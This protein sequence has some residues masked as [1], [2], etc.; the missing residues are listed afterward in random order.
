[1]SQEVSTSGAQ[2]L[3][4]VLQPD[5]SDLQEVVVVGYGTMQKKDL[6]GAVS[7]VQ[8][9]EIAARKTTQVSTALQGA[10]PGLMVTRSGNAPGASATIRVRGITTLTDAGSNPLIILD[11]VPI[12]D[13]NSINPNDIDN[14]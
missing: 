14:I 9:Q 6:T 13:I 3:S 8:G 12:D 2:P 10:V 5:K 1:V 4:I 11:G 7:S